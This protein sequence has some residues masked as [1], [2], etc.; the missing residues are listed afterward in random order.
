[1]VQPA[2]LKS[3]REFIHR[4]RGGDGD[5]KDENEEDMGWELQDVAG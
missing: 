2:M 1:M 4:I 5:D 3:F